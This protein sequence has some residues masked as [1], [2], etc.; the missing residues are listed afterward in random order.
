MGRIV[1]QLEAEVPEDVGELTEAP[2][3]LEMAAA[4]HRLTVA[5]QAVADVAAHIVVS[6]G[7]GAP[8]DY[9]SAVLLL[10]QR[11]VVSRELAERLA[12]AVG[13]R[14]VLVHMYLEVDPKL[15][16]QGIERADDFRAFAA[17]VEEWMHAE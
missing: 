1:E 12:D 7:Y 11:G 15:V 6:E 8:D 5:A 2:E 17:E 13:L 4:E 9:R 10:G 3:G 16:V 14:N